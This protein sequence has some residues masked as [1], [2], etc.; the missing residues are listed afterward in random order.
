MANYNFE[1]ISYNENLYYPRD[2]VN[3]LVK[4][5]QTG[6]TNLWTGN[7]PPG[8]T[9]YEDGLT[10]DY[11]LPHAGNT[12]GASLNLGSVG[13][14]PVYLGNSTT[15]VTNEFPQHSVIRLTYLI[16]SA[17]NSGNGA[18]KVSAYYDYSSGG[19]VTSV[20]GSTGLTGTVTTS[21]SIKANLRSETALTNSSA[22]ATETSGRVYPI[23]LDHDGYLAVNVPWTDSHQTIKQDGVTGATGNHYAVCPTAAFTA[24]KTASITSGTPTLEAGLRVIVNFENANT[25]DSPTLN[26]NNLGH[27][28]IFHNGSRI[29]TG[30][31]KALLAGA[32]EFV[33][34]GT[35]WQFVGNYLNVV[36]LNPGTYNTIGGVKPYKNYTVASTGPT[37]TSASTAITVNEITSVADKYYAVEMDS[38]GRMFVN[39][40]GG[41]TT[42]IIE[43]VDA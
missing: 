20:S 30:E 16:T 25:A 23:A 13:A 12:S 4:G 8:I 5:T 15:Q 40:P 11:Y 1:N 43:W 34:D 7:L 18:W 42:Q 37:P 38:N 14:K 29:T 31:N 17:L 19:T 21:G 27:K 32:V 9:T 6:S 28:N 3:Y 10:I 26:I 35:Q 24:A 22:A 41:T 39:V 36:N 2:T 33:Y